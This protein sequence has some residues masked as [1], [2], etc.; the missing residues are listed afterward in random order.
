MTEIRVVLCPH[1][2]TAT[3][4]MR[5]DP[6]RCAHC[7]R[8]LHGFNE[9]QS[10][11]YKPKSG[12]LKRLMK[13]EETPE[14]LRD[15]A[16]QLCQD[17]KEAAAE[18]E[19]PKP[20][21]K[22][23]PESSRHMLEICVM[24]AHIGKLAWSEE[25]GE[26]Y[27]IKIATERVLTAVDDLLEQ[28]RLFSTVTKIVL[29]WGNDFFHYDTLTGTTTAGTPQDRDSRYQKMFRCGRAL[30]SEVVQK[31]AAIAPVELVVVPGNHDE[32][33]AF[34]LGEVLA[35]EFKD[36]A[37]V[38]VRNELTPRKYVHYGKTLLGYCHGHAEP[39][40]KL[41]GIMALE[42]PDLWAA[43]RYREWHLGHLHTSK[44]TDSKPVESTNGV[45]VRVLQSLTGLD[46][47]HAKMGYVGEP[48][49]CE[50]FVWNHERGLRANLFHHLGQR[51][52]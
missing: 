11:L 4:G 31:C 40:A 41:P 2:N 27:D 44:R 13:Q 10:A 15:L 12:E 38:D 29:P 22:W 32:L 51:A 35:A 7:K 28:S 47:W 36:D 52:A 18:R 43:S 6:N 3:R 20:K 26:N 19:K 34:H 50:A 45:R 16:K 39:H 33:S 8:P 9:A 24:D 48:G 17:I 37:R 25:T 5:V 21:V 30:A 46:N 14:N 49:G 42:E 1:C 23:A